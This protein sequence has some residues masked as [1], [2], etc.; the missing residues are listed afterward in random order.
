M[1][2]S[3]E[4]KQVLAFIESLVPKKVL[5]FQCG[6][7]LVLG[8]KVVA[9]V[10]AQTSQQANAPYMV[11]SAYITQSACN[12]SPAL[13]N[14]GN[15]LVANLPPLQ[16]TVLVD[17]PFS[18]VAPVQLRFKLSE[19]TLSC[20]KTVMGKNPNPVLFDSAFAAVMPRSG[21]LRN[22]ATN[23]PAENVL[24]QLGLINEQG[25]YTP[26]DLNQPQALNLAFSQEP[27][28]SSANLTLNLGVR[29][30]AARYVSEQYASLGNVNLGQGDVTAGN[31]SVLLPFLLT[32]K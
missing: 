7:L 9:P 28:S 6:L 29:Y 21:L 15:P 14:E 10:C 2:C 22:Q 11:I 3:P 32:L 19:D 12:F 16:T 5:A 30:V 4:S 31:V 25:I 17:S 23:R 1:G 27:N 26:L 13:V 18:P 24:V 8:F 20:L